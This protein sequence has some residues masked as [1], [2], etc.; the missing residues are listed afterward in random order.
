MRTATVRDLRNNYLTLMKWLAAGEEIVITRRGRPIA[1][2]TPESTATSAAVDWSQSPTLARDRTQEACL[3][4]A[5]SLEVL[6]DS[7]GRW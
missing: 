1:R 5:E 4:V 6:S 3:S 2:L 7:G